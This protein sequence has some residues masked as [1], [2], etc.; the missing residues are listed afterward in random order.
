MPSSLL[1][2][3]GSPLRCGISTGAIS[4]SKTPFFCA[5]AARWWERAANSSCSARVDAEAG[6]VL[7]GGLAHRDVLE[8]V[9][10][11]VVGHR[12]EHLDRAVLEALAGLGQQVRGVG[13]GLLAAGHHDVELAGADQLVGQRDRVEARTGTPC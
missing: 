8:G 10:Q 9:G 12:V 5:A 7:L 13:H 3:T 1:T 4:A 11:A 6:V 2:T